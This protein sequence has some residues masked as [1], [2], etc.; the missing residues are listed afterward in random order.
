MAET[1]D[2]S[3]V[4]SAPVFNVSDVAHAPIVYFDGVTNF[5]CNNGVV[6]MTLG[7]NRYLAS[8]DGG[9]TGDVIVVSH[10]RCS[11]AA[12][13]DLRAALDKA[14]LINAPTDGQIN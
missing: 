10:L 13:I 12:A 14:L 9:V 3:K 4:P 6:N 7:A 1:T 5:G 8:P 2:P 11:I